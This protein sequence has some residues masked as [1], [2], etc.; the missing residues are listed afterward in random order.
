MGTGKVGQH[1]M[2]TAGLFITGTDTGVGKTYVAC[3]IAR[4]MRHR[5]IAVGAY[6]AACSGS[7]P[8]PGEPRWLDIEALSNACGGRL[9]PE[10]ICPQ[11]FAAPLAPPVAARA[12]GRNV[13]PQLLRTGARWWH[14][15]VELLLAEGAGGLLAPLSDV[16]LVADLAADLRFPLIIVARLGL[17]T[18]NHTLLTVEAA[19]RR[20]LPIAGIVLNEAEPLGADPSAAS[21]S[22]EIA[23]R[24][25]APILG[26]LR[27]NDQ[28][29]LL[30][31]RFRIRMDWLAL[32]KQR[33]RTP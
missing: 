29:G 5:G 18:I 26:I 22:R 30:R 9:P 1:A 6:K 8:G 19:Q 27:R 31:G 20:R 21:N 16:D 23:V 15:S 3:M 13:D 28:S 32:A 12:E 24:C 7:E 25:A 17:G 14:G 10:R 2:K 4:E 33:R 11:R